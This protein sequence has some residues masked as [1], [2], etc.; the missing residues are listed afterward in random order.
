MLLQHLVN[1]ADIVVITFSVDEDCIQPFHLIA[2]VGMISVEMSTSDVR[3]FRCAVTLWAATHNKLLN[4]NSEAP[5]SVVPEDWYNYTRMDVTAQLRKQYVESS[6]E[7]Y[8]TWEEETKHC[9]ED[10]SKALC[11]MGNMAD[12]AKVDCLIKD[13]TCELK[14]IY[15]YLIKLRAVGYDM[16]YI[17][18]IQSCIHKKYK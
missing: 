9:Y 10:Y 5:A 8:K 16:N 6:F 14:T 13:V 15:K 4:C 3:C 11:E 2:V 7:A 18:E 1:C 17:L 12:A